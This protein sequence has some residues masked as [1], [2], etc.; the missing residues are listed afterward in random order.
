M[1]RACSPH[2][3]EDKFIQSFIGKPER[4]NYLQD[5]CVDGNIVLKLKE[6]RCEGVGWIHLPRD[7]EQ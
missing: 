3:R 4:K 7:R 6:V 1:D 2:G 5:L